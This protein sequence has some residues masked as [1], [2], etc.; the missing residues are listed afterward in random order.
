MKE[1]AINTE[2]IKL[3]AFLKYAG[4]INNGSDAKIM[5]IN[6]RIKVNGEIAFQRGKKL[7]DQD[8]VE[9]EGVGE[10]KVKGMA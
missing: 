6:E 10:F 3:S 5:I 9:V 7:K 4:I 2:Y 1:I 8:I